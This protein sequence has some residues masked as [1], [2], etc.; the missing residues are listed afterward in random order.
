VVGKIED[1]W[2]SGCRNALVDKAVDHDAIK[3]ALVAKTVHDF[4]VCLNGEKGTP[5]ST[6]KPKKK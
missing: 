1:N 2:T 3:C 5:Q 4:D 6:G